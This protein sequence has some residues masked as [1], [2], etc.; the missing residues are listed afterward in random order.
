MTEPTYH[1]EGQVIH[2]EG[3]ENPSFDP[4]AAGVETNPAYSGRAQPIISTDLSPAQFDSSLLSGPIWGV[5]MYRGVSQ[6]IHVFG[7]DNPTHPPVGPYPS[8][9][10][11]AEEVPDGPGSLGD[12]L[13]E[14]GVDSACG[15]VDSWTRTEDADLVSG[16]PDL[17]SHDPTYTLGVADTGQRTFQTTEVDNGGNIIPPVNIS[18]PGTCLQMRLPGG[19]LDAV[20]TNH[21]GA[22]FSRTLSSRNRTRDGAPVFPLELNAEF[23]IDGAFEGRWLQGSN[24]FPDQIATYGTVVS[25]QTQATDSIS[26]TIG[27]QLAWGLRFVLVSPSLGVFETDYYV[28]YRTGQTLFQFTPSN[29]F[30]IKEL[31]TGSVVY[32]KTWNFGDVEPAYQ[33]P[34]AFSTASWV[35]AA[36]AN[37]PNGTDII[38]S[39]D[40]SVGTNTTGATQTFNLPV[41]IDV[42][43]T[44]INLEY[45]SLGPEDT[46]CG[47]VPAEGC[48][49]CEDPANPG[50]QLPEFVPGYMPI[51]RRQIGDPTTS[52]D[53]YICTMESGA[54]VLDWHTRG[55]IQV[56]G[57][58]L[59][60]WCGR[61]EASIVG[62]GTNLG[63][64]Q[65]AWRHWD[66][67]LE[68]RSGAGWAGVYA[69]LL[70]GRA[71]ILQGDYGEFN[72]SE[73]CQ[74]NFVDNHAIAVFPYQISDRLLVGD[75]ICH[76]Y[77]GVKISSLQAYAEALS[78]GVLFAV[79]RPW[80]P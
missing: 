50:F 22:N 77:H 60:Q 49:E 8:C 1:G 28:R 5:P 3:D 17:V 27:G 63:N 48:E 35:F 73:R 36:G 15:F 20:P 12:C 52:L 78:P 19:H 59:V 58:E 26:I 30:Y 32:V 66:Q 2:V 53:S 29:H 33:G 4:L 42:D 41:E 47:V 56:W 54:M 34:Y 61:S 25:P 45:W 24:P 74:D 79:S 21:L 31:F 10:C 72:L 38:V 80:T 14:G 7:D 16:V 51:F 40:R 68:I 55:A 57:G 44:L 75:P 71:V 9:R 23:T 11:C 70:E 43:E 69:A 64:V 39:A 62:T 65:T 76:D 18:V 46:D 6:A 67:Y 37:T 13:D